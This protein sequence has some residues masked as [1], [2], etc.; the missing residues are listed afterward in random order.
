MKKGLTFLYI[1]IFIALILNGVSVVYMYFIEA[2]KG[3]SKANSKDES[4]Y[5]NW[6]AAGQSSIAVNYM[7]QPN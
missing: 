3:E 2:F 4:I 5:L 7:Q 1:F 6:N